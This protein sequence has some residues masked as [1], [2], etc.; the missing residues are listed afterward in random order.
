MVV[1]GGE[2]A[3]GHSRIMEKRED[4]LKLLA[5]QLRESEKYD[6]KITLS[7]L[8]HTR[9]RCPTSAIESFSPLSQTACD[10]SRLG[11]TSSR[12]SA[13]HTATVG[14]SGQAIGRRP[15]RRRR[16]KN[17]LNVLYSEI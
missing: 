14:S 13:G 12:Q 7:T 10:R 1:L 2:A 5:Q 11:K 3:D 4:I 16:E 9:K 15:G 6:D 8:A 17:S